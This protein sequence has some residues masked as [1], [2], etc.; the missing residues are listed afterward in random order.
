MIS[1]INLKPLLVRL[2]ATFALLAATHIATAQMMVVRPANIPAAPA[3]KPVSIEQAADVVKHS[4]AK[5]AAQ[6]GKK[7]RKAVRP[8]STVATSSLPPLEFTPTEEQESHSTP[9]L[10]PDAFAASRPV[11]RGV[12]LSSATSHTLSVGAKSVSI[13]ACITIFESGD[14]F[15]IGAMD[16]MIDIEVWQLDPSYKLSTPKAYSDFITQ[17]YGAP[18]RNSTSGNRHEISGFDTASGRNFHVTMVSEGDKLYVA[19]LLY[20]PA[21]ETQVSELIIPNLLNSNRQS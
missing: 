8:A 20:K 1:T 14:D 16:N 2:A 15:L 6:A 3:V 18:E 19:R 4:K 10:N 13:P 11:S 12:E 7:K 9:R 17:L 5:T 21:I